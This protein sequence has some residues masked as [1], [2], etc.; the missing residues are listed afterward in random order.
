MKKIITIQEKMN[1]VVKTLPDV[2]GY[3][4]GYKNILIVGNLTAI[5]DQR[6]YYSGRG[7][8]YNSS[9][10]HG[11]TTTTMTER[12]LNK[13]YKVIVDREKQRDLAI[14][15]AN[16][17]RKETEARY[18]KTAKAGLYELATFD[19]GTFVEL[20]QFEKE[21]KTFDP[22]RLAA[23][24]DITVEDATLL[25]SQGKTYVFA[26]QISTGKIIELYHSALSCNNLSISIT[27]PSAERIAEFKH[28]EWA[29][30]PYASQVGMSNKK[31]HFVC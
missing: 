13:A 23:T 29:S 1:A 22:N 10:R 6:E 2:H 9:I 20:S 27:Y 7:A 26:T 24:L 31:N 12:E 18:E 4:M 19:Y 8:K 15:N 16:I 25:F 21:N 14:N 30:A 11:G 3:K 17:Q 28:E 5:D